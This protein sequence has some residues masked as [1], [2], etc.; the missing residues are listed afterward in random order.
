MKL[1]TILPFFL[2]TSY[3]A[4]I[5]KKCYKEMFNRPFHINSANCLQK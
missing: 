4:K 2:Q 1:P 3:A 5:K